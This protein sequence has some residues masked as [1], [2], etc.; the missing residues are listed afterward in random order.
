MLDIEVNSKGTNKAI[1][2]NVLSDEMMREIG[3]TS[4]NP[5]TWYFYKD[6]GNEI[7]FDVTIPKDGS[8]IEIATID[9]EWGQYYDYQ[10][11]LQRNLQFEFALN[12]KEKVEKW[13]TYLTEKGVIYGWNPGDYI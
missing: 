9:E 1:K 10:G 13:M 11:I 8:D 12:I 7:T 5:N 2:A 4:Y 3:F 6:L